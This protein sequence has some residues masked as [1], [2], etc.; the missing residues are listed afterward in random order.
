M[1]MEKNP[2]QKT[3]RQDEKFLNALAEAY[4]LQETIIGTTELSIISTDT[5]GLITS[6]NKAAETMLGYSAEEVIGKVT[7]AIFHDQEEVITRSK[8]LSNEL[9]IEIIPGFE[10]F[11]AKARINKTADRNEWAYVRK[12]QTQFPVLLSITGL[13][14]EDNL[15]GY[16]G[17]A[18][19]ITGSKKKEF[20]LKKSEAHLQA[21][22][23]SIDDIAFELNR[24]RIYTNVWTKD[25][26]LLIITPRKEY[27]G[28]KL[29]QVISGETLFRMDSAIE[30]VFISQQPQ[31]VE[32]LVPNTDRWS[33]TKISYIDQDRVLM[34][35]RNITERKKAE[36]ELAKSEHKFRAMAENIPG[37]IYLRSNDE[38]STMVYLNDYVTKI[39]GYSAS[40]F[41]SNTIS[42]V[43]LYHPEYKEYIFNLVDKALNDHVSFQLEYRIKHKSGEWRWLEEVGTGVYANDSLIMIEGFISDITPRKLAEEEL[44]RMADEHS[45]VFNNSIHLNCV[46]NFDGYFIKLN[47]AWEKTLGWTLEELKTTKFREFIHTD[48]QNRTEDMVA[49]ISAGNSVST[50]EN[51]YRCKD[52]SYR[53]L[54]WSSSPDINRKLIYA[55]AIDITERKKSEEELERIAN[56]NFRVFNNSVHLN[57]IANLE[58]YFVKLNPAWEKILGWTREELKSKRFSEF[59]LSDD[60]DKTNRYFK[61]L[62]AGNDMIANENRYR[63]KDGTYRWLL[64]SSS[65]DKER[66]LIYSSAIDITARKKSEEELERS[67]TSLEVAALELQEQNRQLDDF[68][69]IVSHNMRSPIGNIKALIGFLNSTSTIDDYRLIFGKLIDVS[70]NLNETMNELLET[71]KFKKNADVVQSEIRFDGILNKV[72]QSLQGEIIQTG[73]VIQSE[74]QAP[75]L[76]YSKT[77]LES[78][79]QNI[80]SNAIKYRSTIRILE[81]FVR[82]IKIDGAIELRISDNGL[83]IDMTLHGDK[84]FG[85][86]KTFHEHKDARGVGLFLVKTQIEALGGSIH[87]ESEVDKGTTFIIRF[88]Q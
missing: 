76:Q 86:H 71:L 3:Y 12:D 64:W 22:L 31:Y 29:S 51:R 5:K 13:W 59:V 25:E 80:I 15:I 58:G 61:H 19:D 45:R 72:I 6:F 46:A 83:G 36:M 4:R 57:C 1:T 30:T 34:L 14:E 74:F 39:T 24:D 38:K 33:S 68:A 84:L 56:E 50:F 8:V 11:V 49:H 81:I 40:E 41:I 9:G 42:F 62:V 18:T 65:M 26:S 27:V 88:A 60:Q 85:L 63:C 37:A 44:R 17:I 35:A 10:T 7:P 78:V 77:H 87:A 48:D 20:L 53:W 21:L 79:F 67:N 69:H 75:S 66:K 47:Q 43:Q 70:E 82:T 73:A 54:L 52:G 2:L 55:S 23:N 32:F 28:K 16:A